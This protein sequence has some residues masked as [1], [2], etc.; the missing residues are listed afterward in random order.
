MIVKSFENYFYDEIEDADE[1][2]IAVGLISENKA[3][4]FCRIKGIG[5]IWKLN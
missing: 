4:C 2:L 5:D 1:V 3:T